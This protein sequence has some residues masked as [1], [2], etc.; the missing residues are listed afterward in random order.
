MNLT[1]GSRFLFFVLCVVSTFET[2]TYSDS[3]HPKS[4]KNVPGSPKRLP[5]PAPNRIE[6]RRGPN[7]GGFSSAVT[8]RAALSILPFSEYQHF[9][10]RRLM[11][12]WKAEK[13]VRRMNR[14][15]N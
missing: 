10:N 7:E 3:C 2:S 6:T 4:K 11:M 1:P 13:V 8:V 15:E 5:D 12:L 14:G 9:G